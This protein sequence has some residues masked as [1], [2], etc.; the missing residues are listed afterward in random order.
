M[1]V[2]LVVN[3][4]FE[5][6]YLSSVGHLLKRAD[7]N[8]DLKLLTNPKIFTRLNS[9]I[10]RLFSNIEVVEY[11]RISRSPKR[12]YTNSQVFIKKVR[13]I[14]LSADVLCI[15]SF[16]EY[17]AN[18]LCN[19]LKKEMRLV[20]FRMA[21]HECENLCDV[22]KPLRSLYYNLFNR[23]FGISAMEY[24][25][26]KD[27][28][29]TSSL[30]YKQNPYD[31]TICISDWGMGQNNGEF[32]LPPPFLALREFYKLGAQPMNNT[33]VFIGERTPIYE[34]WG[35]EDQDQYN[36]IFDFLRE[37]FSE[38]RLLFRP[39][40]G[41]TELDKMKSSLEGFEIMDPSIPFEEF[42]TR[43][44]YCK[45]ISIK[46]T[47]CKVAAYYGIPSYLLYPIFN[48]PLQ[49]QSTVEAY[50]SDMKSIVRVKKTE[51]ILSVKTTL[52]K[53]GLDELS[54]LYWRAVLEGI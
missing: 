51:D 53:Q 47:A 48:L 18:I 3:T 32:R 8:L 25:W 28:A 36:L 50:L 49:F 20:A 27:T 46:S 16:R 10:K 17:F 19:L 12:S 23:T 43:N 31:R 35:Q 29:H 22:K 37:N 1:R 42:C 15:S 6:Y 26:H 52:I 5:L 33:I 11:P 41:F 44:H 9:D 13:D 38:H 4:I 30:W 34:D 14:D 7:S 40:P 54:D 24:R 21:D 39:R 2:L 45:V